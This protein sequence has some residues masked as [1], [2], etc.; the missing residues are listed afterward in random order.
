MTSQLPGFWCFFAAGSWEEDTENRAAVTALRS[1][2]F[3]DDFRQ[4]DVES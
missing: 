1:F 3:R 4:C 2:L